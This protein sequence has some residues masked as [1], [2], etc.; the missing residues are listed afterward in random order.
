M[1]RHSFRFRVALHFTG[2]GALASVLLCTGAYFFAHDLGQRLMDEALQAEMQDH[3]ATPQ[4]NPPAA[5]THN[6]QILEASHSDLPA[7]LRSL[8]SGRHDVLLDGVWYRVLAAEHLGKQDILLF[9]ESLQRQRERV[10]LAFLGMGSVAM[11]LL[12]ALGGFWL[13]RRIVAPVEELAA[14][15]GAAVPVAASPLAAVERDLDEVEE[16]AL[17]FDRY[18]A[19]IQSCMARERDFTANVSHELRTPLAIIRGALEVLEED[20]ALSSEQ[21]Q[22]LARIERASHDMAGLT[23]ALLHLAREESARPGESESSD[24]AEV[25][26]TTVEK[27]R[28]MSPER[29][30]DIHMDISNDVHLPVARIL[31]AVVV[32]NLVGNALQHAGATRID[33]RLRQDRLVICDTGTGIAPHDLIQVFERHYR[34]ASSSGAGI[35]LSLVKRIC[36][37]NGWETQIKSVPGQGTKVS[38]TFIASAPAS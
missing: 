36:D 26:R 3:L 4:G 8:V 29:S 38:L 33:I 11:I 30:P 1:R 10:F 18:L 22:R 23:S 25:V 34:G 37:L 6:V 31:A 32:D 19:R 16:L 13:A 24:M 27:Y 17:L 15:V 14:R 7:A 20:A 28:S 35:G 2:F 9:N 5:L 21:R 12:S